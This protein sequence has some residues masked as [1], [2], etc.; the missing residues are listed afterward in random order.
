MTDRALLTRK[1]H[2]MPLQTATRHFQQRTERG[3]VRTTALEKRLRR[4]PKPFR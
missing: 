1:G 2:P 3:T 4:L